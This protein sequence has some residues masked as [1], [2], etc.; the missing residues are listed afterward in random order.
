MKNVIPLGGYPAGQMAVVMAKNSPG[1][2]LTPIRK[3]PSRLSDTRSAG[4]RHRI[5][6]CPKPFR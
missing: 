5:G 2:K 6:I 3:F 4:K 1:S